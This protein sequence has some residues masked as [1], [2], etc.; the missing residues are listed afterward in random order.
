M[1]YNILCIDS[2]GITGLEISRVLKSKQISI[3]NAS[4]LE[5]AQRLSKQNEFHL[6]IWRINFSETHN[7][8]IIGMLKK[9]DEFKQIP[10]IV[11]SNFSGKNHVINAIENG[12]NEYIAM[13]CDDRIILE[14]VC[15]MLNIPAGENVVYNMENELITL[16]FDEF[17]NREIKSAGR[18]NYPVS[19]LLTC[20]V[21]NGKTGDY[22]EDTGILEIFKAVIIARLR[23]TDM[24]FKFSNNSILTVLPFSDVDG[25]RNV[26]LKITDLFNSHSLLKK[27]VSQYKLFA[28]SVTFPDDSRQKKTLLEML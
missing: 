27:Y 28:S 2:H 11:I 26:S 1:R 5:Q 19:F 24:V 22:S 13:P 20:L 4:D 8:K 7:Y 25:A 12:A 23:D 10:V 6:I 9:Q 16:S 18:G 14:K 21:P 15:G 3:R 17:V